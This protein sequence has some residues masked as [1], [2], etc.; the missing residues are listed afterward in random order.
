MA[1]HTV[2]VPTLLV[3]ADYHKLSVQHNDRSK[4]ATTLVHQLHVTFY[5]QL[6]ASCTDTYSNQ[7]VDQITGAIS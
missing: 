6:I 5:T 4:Q 1:Q 3:T 7:S 2:A